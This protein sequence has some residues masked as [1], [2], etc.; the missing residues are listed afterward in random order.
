LPLACIGACAPQDPSPEP[1]HVSTIRIGDI[2][3]GSL[4]LHVVGGKNTAEVVYRVEL[5]KPQPVTIQ[6]ESLD[7]DN[8][9]LL[10]D[11]GSAAKASDHNSGAYSNAWLVW[12]AGSASELLVTIGSEDARGGEFKLAVASGRV[13]P[14]PRGSLE[15][16]RASIAYCSAAST[17]AEQRDE[18]D[19]ASTLLREATLLAYGISALDDA[20]QLGERH[21]RL[22]KQHDQTEQILYAQADLGAVDLLLRDYDSA[23]SLLTAALLGAETHLAL[24]NADPVQAKQRSRFFCFLYQHL[25]DLA[26]AR[27]GPH[28]ALDS[29][30]KF[31]DMAGLSEDPTY[32]ALAWQRMCDAFVAAGEIQSAEHAIE[33]ALARL[34][35]NRSSDALAG[36]LLTKASLLQHVERSEEAL[37][38][39]DKALAIVRDPL[40]HAALLGVKASAHIDVGSYEEAQ[41]A[42]DE[43]EAVCA[44]HNIRAYDVQIKISRAVIAFRLGDYSNARTIL[45]EA[46]AL[47]EQAGEP[48]SRVD[49]LHALATVEGATGQFEAAKARYVAALEICRNRGERAREG[50]VM[51]DL[52]KLE[53]DHGHVR[54]SLDLLQAAE[55]QFDDSADAIH[56]AIAR[57]GRAQALYMSGALD[58]AVEPATSA[59]R[60]LESLGQ[61]EN[62]TD[63]EETLARVGLAKRDAQAV[64]DALSAGARLLEHGETQRLDPFAS[65][66]LR[67]RFADW[68]AIQQ[69]FVALQLT[70]VDLASD[71]RH[72][73][74][75]D[76]WKEA[77]QWKGR[78]LSELIRKH[79]VPVDPSAELLA[80][81]NALAP[82]LRSRTALIEYADGLKSLYVYVL[83]PSGLNRIELGPREAIEKDAQAYVATISTVASS[84][85]EV[86][87]QGERLYRELIAPILPV[88]APDTSTLIVVPTPALAILPFDALVRPSSSS[89]P[90]V[91]EFR[92]LHFLI[93]DYCVVASPSSTVLA[94]LDARS[95]S[96]RRERCLIVGDPLYWSELDLSP[97][98]ESSAN[99]RSKSPA[100][101]L[102]R[103]TS[104]RD[105]SVEV[106]RLLLRR[107]SNA[108]DKQ[109]AQ[110]LDLQSPS[111]R[112]ARMSTESFD[113]VMG[114]EANSEILKA[115]LSAYT[116]VHIA[117]HGRIDP[118]DPRRSALVLAYDAK[119]EGIFAMR[120][121]M[122]MHLDADLVVLSACDTARGKIVRGEGVQSLAYGFIHAGARSVIA[123]FWRVNDS[124][125]ATLMKSFYGAYLEKGMLAPQALH[126]AKLAFRHSRGFRGEPPVKGQSYSS[127]VLANPFFWASCV[128]IGPPAK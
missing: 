11:R 120:D 54:E 74:I 66:G 83:L 45:L 71:Q 94:A 82:T 12:D 65:A 107:A 34:A 37:P 6:V 59:A 36:A 104:T 98:H 72:R 22:S 25:G 9:L 100:R 51:L 30:R 90:E 17:R 110:L 27:E 78:V 23:A 19:R 28:A 32:Q 4:P 43:L 93:D 53:Q 42:T 64:S 112:T 35:D 85:M 52:A 79:E 87:E 119:T 116:C 81:E 49:V 7:F 68:G 111:V 1:F 39:C 97:V 75:A 44:K 15:W 20:K 125:T 21:L 10:Q 61:W 18:F 55:E 2:V 76:G 128:F 31:V 105:E 73:L 108:T 114:A 13:E 117:A 24:S 48:M 62:A 113:L 80:T 47:Q 26:M 50:N 84:P 14:P 121:V 96:R 67:S 38:A 63:A 91:P 123:T 70:S 88:L 58:A 77:G 8:Q 60:V 69:D 89:A 57:V 103:L 102:G 127:Y 40:V 109:R 99:S 3:T 41:A 101:E 115:D 122:G 16:T 95:V 29:Y 86:A 124:E 33:E 92:E 118:E 106:A 126:Q 56:A 46:L 5:P